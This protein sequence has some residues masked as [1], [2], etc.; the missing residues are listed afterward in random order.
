MGDLDDAI[1]EHLELKRMRGA[2]PNEVARLEHEALGPIDRGRG[3]RG[4]VAMAEHADAR[5]LLAEHEE[6]VTAEHGGGFEA[7]ASGYEDAAP[8]Y[9]EATPYDA[10]G[11]SAAVDHYDLPT[12]TDLPAHDEG[13]APARPV[14]AGVVIP[15]AADVGDETQEFRLDEDGTWVDPSAPPA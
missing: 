12:H 3:S 15:A 14:S 4:G 11:E 5:P 8:G 7:P 6:Y 1:R 13:P 9:A 10:P 2:D